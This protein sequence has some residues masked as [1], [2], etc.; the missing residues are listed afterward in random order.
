[1]FLKAA[2]LEIPRSPLLTGVAG[3]QYKVCKATKNGKFSA[4]VSLMVFLSEYLSENYTTANCRFKPCVFL[5][6]QR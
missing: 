1:M 5:K 4:N 2:I 3:L 6:L